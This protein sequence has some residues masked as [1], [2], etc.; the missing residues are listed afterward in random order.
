[1]EEEGSGTW[2]CD[3]RGLNDM[4]EAMA[5]EIAGGRRVEMPLRL[6]GVHRRGVVIARR[7]AE[8][9][10]AILGV[11]VP[12]GAVDITLYRD[13]L[14]Q[15]P[16]WPVLRGTELPFPVEGAEIVLVDDV[17]QTG[18]TVRAAINALCDHGRP[19]MVRLAVVV[20]RDG[21]ELPIRPDVVGS[22]LPAR[23]GEAIRVRIAPVDEEEGILREPRGHAP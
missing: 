4:I 5:R 12:V 20:D 16:A 8:R 11:E 10:A 18:R 9:L 2:L 21:R 22:A 14:G 6:V 19:G 15:R 7:L 23:P 13:D 1:M 17:L 3:A